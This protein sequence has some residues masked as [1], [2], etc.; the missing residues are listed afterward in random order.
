MLHHGVFDVVFYHLFLLV[1]LF[2]PKDARELRQ[3]V[4]TAFH[5]F[6]KPLFY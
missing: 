3:F 6:N 1:V 5:D 4:N 2:A